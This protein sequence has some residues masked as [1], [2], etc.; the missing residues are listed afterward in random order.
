[1]AFIK[2]RDVDCP[3][4]AYNLR[5]LP[6]PRC[7]E[8]GRHI[9]WKDIRPLSVLRLL[10]SYRLTFFG[11]AAIACWTT[12]IQFPLIHAMAWNIPASLRI[13][14]AADAVGIIGAGVCIGLFVRWWARGAAIRA[15]PHLERAAVSGKMLMWS[16]LSAALTLAIGMGVPLVFG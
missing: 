4:C 5:D 12:L 9:R 13:R 6:E 8:C 11:L 15:L 1:M 7:P 3:H 16:I 10:F 14:L 2:G